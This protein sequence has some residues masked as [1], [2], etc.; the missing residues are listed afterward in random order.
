MIRQIIRSWF[1]AFAM[2]FS[3]GRYKFRFVEESPEDLKAWTI[4]IVKDGDEPDSLIFKCPCGCE[5]RVE[6]NLLT[7]CRPQWTFKVKGKKISISPSVWATR[8][9]RSHFWIREGRVQW[10][11]GLRRR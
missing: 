9:C 7:D 1:D 8:G 4:Y 3:K 5:S 6:L 10:T 11:S 2:R